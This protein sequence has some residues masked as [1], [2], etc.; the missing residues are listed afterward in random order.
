M[1]FR[2]HIRG[3][4]HSTLQEDRA[5]ILKI[6]ILTKPGNDGESFPEPSQQ[7]LSCVERDSNSGAGESGMTQTMP[8]GRSAI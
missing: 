6:R 1:P 3:L 2:A 8:L 5:H 4:P 7:P